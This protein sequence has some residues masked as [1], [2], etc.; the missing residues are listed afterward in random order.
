M[1]ALCIFRVIIIL[2]SVLFAS[3]YKFIKIGFMGLFQAMF[4]SK[5]LQCLAAER[6]AGT[7]KNNDN[8]LKIC[9]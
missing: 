3:C 2:N 1:S 8:Y 7:I 5:S 9:R 6:N 4:T